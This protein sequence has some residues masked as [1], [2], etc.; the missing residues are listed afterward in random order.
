MKKYYKINKEHPNFISVDLIEY[1]KTVGGYLLPDRGEN[2]KSIVR[3]LK[4]EGYIEKKGI[5]H[6]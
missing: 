1:D 3:Y 5:N 2:K 4:K 6:E